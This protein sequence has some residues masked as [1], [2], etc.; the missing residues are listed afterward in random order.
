MS[1]SY[2]IGTVSRIHNLW[3]FARPSIPPDPQSPLSR[4]AAMEAAEISEG[5]K[6]IQE[7]KLES[8]VG[9]MVSLDHTIYFHRPRDIRADE[10]LC[11]EME[12]PWGGEGRGLVFQRIWNRRGELVASCVQEVSHRFL[13][14][15]FAIFERSVL[16]FVYRFSL[17]Q[18][19]IWKPPKTANI[20]ADPPM[21]YIHGLSN[22]Y[23]LF[24]FSLLSSYSIVIHQFHVL[25]VDLIAPLLI[26]NKASLT[27]STVG[28]C[29]A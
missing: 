22:V 13:S 18:P 21:V 20:C 28:S 27:S 17:C 9:M 2:F 6:G 3:R 14:L 4:I 23:V 25:P 8:R 19:L 12:S 24:M 26:Y 16:T 11:A 10:W 5:V 7:G 1:D 29:T 15:L